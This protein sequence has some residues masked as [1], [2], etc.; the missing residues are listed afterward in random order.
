MQE[1]VRFWAQY[2][3]KTSSYKQALLNFFTTYDIM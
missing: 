3:H 1:S 2:R